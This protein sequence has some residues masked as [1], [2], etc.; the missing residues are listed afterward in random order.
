MEIPAITAIISKDVNIGSI[1]IADGY[2]PYPKSVKNLMSYP[3]IVLH[4]VG[5]KN[6]KEFHSN[7]NENL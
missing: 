3:E 4:N 6:K 5:F 7:N 1:V 2:P